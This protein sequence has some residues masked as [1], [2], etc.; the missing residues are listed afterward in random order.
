MKLSLKILTI[1]FIALCIIS[2]LIY[3]Y[4][5]FTIKFGDREEYA[6]YI[7]FFWILTL[8]MFVTACWGGIEDKVLRA[9]FVSFGKELSFTNMAVL[10]FSAYHY[11]DN[12]DFYLNLILTAFLGY[13]TYRQVSLGLDNRRKLISHLWKKLWL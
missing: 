7:L 4:L 9:S 6:D 5:E 3:S 8:G 12:I 1:A 13:L 10:Y 11:E 2:P